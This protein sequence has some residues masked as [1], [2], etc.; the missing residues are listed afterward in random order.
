MAR[1]HSERTSVGPTTRRRQLGA[2][3]KR[4]RDLEGLT[5]EV[6]GE[7]A[8]V[9]RATLNRYE[10]NRGP[11]KWLVV[12]A[13]CRAYGTTDEERAALVSMAK[14]AK[15]Q[16]WWKSY[17]DAIPGWITPLLTLEDEAVEECH[18]ANTYVP[19]LLQT[20]D[21]ATAVIQAAEVRAEAELIERMVSV[22]MKRQEV[23]KREAPPH[24]WAIMDEAVVRRRVGS[25]K[26]MAEQ[27]EHL[28][29]AATTPHVTLQILPFAA[30][31]HAA[32]ST[33]FIIIRG[34]EPSLDVVHL[35][36]LSGALYLEKTAELERHRVVFEYLR[37]QAL[38]TSDTSSLLAELTREFTAAASRER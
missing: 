6:A 9:S 22:R 10:S 15:V 26:V 12:D 24:V 13:L 7:A 16:G 35:S 21:Y 37:S 4:L 23:L 11:V 17:N 19:G 33:S 3:L 18:W 5:L 34:P 14:S 20:P 25:P 36:N 28:R 30:G 38:S 32:E 27:L 29:A 1:T 2:E 31:A 8:G